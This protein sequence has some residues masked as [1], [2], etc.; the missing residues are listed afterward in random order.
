MLTDTKVLSLLRDFLR[1]PKPDWCGPIDVALTSIFLT[2]KA[3]D[4]GV[5]HSHATLAGYAGCDART[6]LRALKQLEDRGWVNVARRDYASNEYA[7]DIDKLPFAEEGRATL[8]VSPEAKKLA[9]AHKRHVL[10]KFRKAL[11]RDFSSVRNIR[12][13]G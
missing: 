11:R 9:L 6:V 7:L 3:L 8:V 4:H 10:S 5:N 2:F 13:N 12:R 1:A